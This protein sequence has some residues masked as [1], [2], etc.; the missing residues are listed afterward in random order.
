MREKRKRNHQDGQ[1]RA[2]KGGKDRQDRKS[3]DRERKGGR[4][5]SIHECMC[6]RLLGGNGRESLGQVEERV[7]E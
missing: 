1:D 5:A 2:K 3:K 6:A 7:V 4:H